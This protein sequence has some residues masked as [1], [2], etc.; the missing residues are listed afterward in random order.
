MSVSKWSDVLKKLPTED[1][2]YYPLRAF[3]FKVIFPGFSSDTSFQDV[4]GL[5]R[6][7]QTDD[8]YEGGENSLVHRL[9]KNVKYPKLV[10]KRG[11]TSKKSDLVEWCSGILEGGFNQ[12]I[13][14]RS[15]HVLLM[16]AEGKAVRS[17]H[18]RNV[19]PVKWA[20]DSLNS[21]KN[22]IAIETIEL[23]YSGFDVTVKASK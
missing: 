9:P 6:E 4:S 13:A 1:A 2:T 11:V 17:W 15:A 20:V 3:Y 21:T 22:E 10:L 16:N 8:I 23:S 14:T 19:Y 7:I 12:K 18:F 5:E